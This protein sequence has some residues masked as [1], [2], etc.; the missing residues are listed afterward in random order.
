MLY[1][2]PAVPEKYASAPSRWT[3][4]SHFRHHCR[5]LPGYCATVRDALTD[6]RAHGTGRCGPCKGNRGGPAMACQVDSRRPEALH[7]QSHMSSLC[8]RDAFLQASFLWNE[9]V[10]RACPLIALPGTVRCMVLLVGEPGMHDT[11]HAYMQTFYENTLHYTRRINL[12]MAQATPESAC[13]PCGER[14]WTGA[15]RLPSICRTAPS[16]WNSV[17]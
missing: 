11:M 10:P 3:G 17:M 1:S 16:V 14:S 7:A 13:A 8:R 6:S 5:G 15:L 2:A 9:T 12:Y 4:Q